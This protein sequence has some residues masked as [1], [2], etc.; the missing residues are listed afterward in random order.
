MADLKDRAE[1]I[2]KRAEYHVAKHKKAES[3][4]MGVYE[5]GLKRYPEFTPLVDKVVRAAVQMINAEAGK[6]QS[7]MPYKAQFTLEEVIRELQERV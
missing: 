7:E 2:K 3:P 1:Q 6:V 5:T 4:A